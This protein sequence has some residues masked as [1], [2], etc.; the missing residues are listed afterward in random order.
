MAGMASNA[1]AFIRST[2]GLYRFRSLNIFDRSEW[3]WILL[4]RANGTSDV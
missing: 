1:K 3:S 2:L 4:Y